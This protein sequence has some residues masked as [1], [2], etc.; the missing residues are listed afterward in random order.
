M[1]FSA[2]PGNVKL[3]FHLNLH[4]LE[5]VFLDLDLQIGLLLFLVFR[6]AHAFHQ[7]VDGRFEVCHATIPK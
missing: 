5:W 7:I 2:Q 6:D 3:L 4:E 1:R